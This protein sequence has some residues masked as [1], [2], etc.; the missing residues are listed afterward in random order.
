MVRKSVTIVLLEVCQS[1]EVDNFLLTTEICL[2]RESN[3]EEKN[4]TILKAVKF[5]LHS[6]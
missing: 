6:F 3:F 2:F 1:L 5:L 4:S